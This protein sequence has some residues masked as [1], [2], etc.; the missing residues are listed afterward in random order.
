V[1]SYQKYIF[2]TSDETLRALL[3]EGLDAFEAF[4]E[5]ETTLTAYAPEGRDERALDNARAYLSAFGFDLPKY[6]RSRVEWQNWNATWEAEF[7]PTAVD[8]YVLL[9]PAHRRAEAHEIRAGYRYTLE[10]DPRMAFG[11][12]RHE[13]TRLCLRALR[14]CEDESGLKGKRVL[15]AGCGTGVLG[16]TAA[17]AGAAVAFADTDP[18][19]VEDTLLNSAANGLSVPPENVRL[20]NAS[21]FWPQRFDL[22]LANLTRNALMA[23]KDVYYALLNTGGLWVVSGFLT[24]DVPAL[25][26]AFSLFTCIAHESE[27]EWSCLTL[28]K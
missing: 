18:I 24:C 25:R 26:E 14:R 10:I 16:L 28:L 13:T 22:I 11:T 17:C 20:G 4:E 19:A 2:H 3:A 15:D 23:E 7:G 27:N 5:T 21:V 8:D 12:G 1:T 6:E 9:Y